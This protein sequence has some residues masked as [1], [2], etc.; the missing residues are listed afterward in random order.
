MSENIFETWI[1]VALVKVNNLHTSNLI[2]HPKT[3]DSFTLQCSNKTRNVCITSL[4]RA[5][6]INV[7]IN[8][9]T[10]W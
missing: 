9:V 7:V 2:K 6:V 10:T 4:K 5:Y 8:S 1:K 3:L